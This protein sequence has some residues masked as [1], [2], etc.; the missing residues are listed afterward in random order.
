MSDFRPIPAL[1]TQIPSFYANICLF[2]FHCANN[3]RRQV[4]VSR[5]QSAANYDTHEMR[6]RGGRVG[7]CWWQFVLCECSREII[8]AHNLLRQ[9]EAWSRTQSGSRSQRG[10]GRISL[11]IMWEYDLMTKIS[12]WLLTHPCTCEMG[13][14][15]YSTTS[16]LKFEIMTRAS[17]L[18]MP[19]TERTNEEKCLHCSWKWLLCL[20]LFHFMYCWLVLDNTVHKGTN[21]C[22]IWV[23]TDAMIKVLEGFQ[24]RVCWRLAGQTARKGD[25]GEC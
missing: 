25:G 14:S 8:L 23:V 5:L 13:S 3:V 6:G 9:A 16:W 18:I 15:S 11:R 20:S 7:A 2:G 10:P 22:D 17:F 24:H 21:E 4:P 19:S 12:I 1:H